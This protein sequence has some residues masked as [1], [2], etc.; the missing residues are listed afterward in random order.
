MHGFQWSC[1]LEERLRKINQ[2]KEAQKQ[3]E[4]KWGGTGSCLH[5]HIQ[6]SI[7]RRER[8][9]MCRA[10]CPLKCTWHLNS[11]AG[12]L[13]APR[14]SIHCGNIWVNECGCLCEKTS[15]PSPPPKTSISL[16][17]LHT[18]SLLPHSG[19][20]SALWGGDTAREEPSSPPLSRPGLLDFWEADSFR[21]RAI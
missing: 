7:Y 2:V 21:Q 17:H 20:T 6:I 15:Q 5:L 4:T 1:K 11:C 19:A 16:L 13:C 3:R 18:H 14:I 10:S 12:P 8:G 9:T